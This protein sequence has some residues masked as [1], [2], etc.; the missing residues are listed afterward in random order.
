M[1]SEAPFRSI[2][3]LGP[4]LIGGSVL[5]AIKERFP[6]CDVRVWARRE[7][8][9][10]TLR[11]GNSGVDLATTSLTEAVEGAECII[12]AMPTGFMG[13]VAEQMPELVPLRGKPVVVTDVGSVKESVEEELGPL[14]SSKGGVFIG[15]HPMAGSEKNGL[16]YASSDLFESAAVIMTPVAGVSED[17]VEALALFWKQLGARVSLMSGREHDETVAAI[18]HLP[19][20]IASALTRS[21]L[22]D[23]P[24]LASYC[25]GGFRDTTRVAGGL[26]D[27][28]TGILADNGPAVS[29][30]LDSLLKELELWKEA[31]D[32]L[33]RDRLRSFLSE[34]RELRESL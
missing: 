21:M 30:S 32:V 33:D 20:L 26:E 5:L 2:A 25:G 24:G 7:S 16:E 1:S 22:K 10:E 34:A 9:V 18:S 4:G 29:Q 11:S 27:M 19:H 8:V 15:S 3:V 31:L 14:I 23:H 28:W 17:V 12:F 6:A 13:G